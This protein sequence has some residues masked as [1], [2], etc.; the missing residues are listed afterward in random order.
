VSRLGPGKLEREGI[1]VDPPEEILANKLCTLLSRGEVRGLVDVL[2]LER[3]GFSV[4][5]ALS[6]AATK[7]GG[8]TAAQLAWVLSQISVG[9]DVRV[10]A[11]ITPAELRVFLEGLVERLLR[12]AHPS[13]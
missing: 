6:S 2:L 4:E 9:P 13:S 11:G 1:L 8:L 10:P 7:D 3:A 5:S 12:L